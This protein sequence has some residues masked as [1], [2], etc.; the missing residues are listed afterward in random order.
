MGFI[1]RAHELVIQRSREDARGHW[2]SKEGT[3]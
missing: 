3:E 2:T 1:L